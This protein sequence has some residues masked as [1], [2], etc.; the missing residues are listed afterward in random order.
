MIHG[1]N[2]QECRQ[3]AARLATQADLSD[4]RLYFTVKELKKTSFQPQFD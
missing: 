2:E 3:V 4:Y 1:R